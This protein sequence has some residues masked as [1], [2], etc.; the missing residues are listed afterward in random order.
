MWGETALFR[1]WSSIIL[2]MHNDYLHCTF[3]TGGGFQ[4]LSRAWAF[5]QERRIGIQNGPFG[6]GL[7]GADCLRLGPMCGFHCSPHSLFYFIGSNGK[8][9]F[10]SFFMLTT[11][12]P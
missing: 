3:L 10:Q 5:G 9:R 8:I 7:G 11:V 6:A 4:R 2:F 1:A 12:Q